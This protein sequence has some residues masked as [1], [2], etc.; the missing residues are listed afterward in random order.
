[1]FSFRLPYEAIFG[2]VRKVKL[3]VRNII[4]ISTFIKIIL[5]FIFFI[6]FLFLILP[7]VLSFSSSLLRSS[8]SLKLSVLYQFD[9]TTP[10]PETD[11]KKSEDKI[12]DPG[13]DRLVRRSKSDKVDGVVVCR[14]FSSSRGSSSSLPICSRFGGGLIF[15]FL[16]WVV[17]VT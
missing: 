14:R 8:N 13:H 5:F 11:T 17:V 10:E 1:M 6:L 16:L 12:S 3:K 4:L 15:F 9:S 2:F 7:V